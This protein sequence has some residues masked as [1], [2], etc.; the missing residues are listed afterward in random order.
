MLMQNQG[1]PNMN[2]VGSATI[3]MPN[4]TQM[5]GDGNKDSPFFFFLEGEEK[6]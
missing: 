5:G 2:N 1:I 4:Q 3:G 6:K